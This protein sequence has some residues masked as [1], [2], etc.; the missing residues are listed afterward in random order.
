MAR[1]WVA[2]WLTAPAPAPL[3]ATPAPRAPVTAAEPANTMALILWVELASRVRAPAA[4]MLCGLLV[5]TVLTLV[6]GASSAAAQQALEFEIPIGF[7]AET[8]AR[9]AVEI[10]VV[11]AGEASHLLALGLLR[12]LGR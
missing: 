9:E 5:G 4:A 1:T 6:L 7:A 8:A 10:P 11:S 2:I 12:P 3:A